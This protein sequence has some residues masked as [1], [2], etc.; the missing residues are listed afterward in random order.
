MQ[1]QARRDVQVLKADVDMLGDATFRDRH[2]QRLTDEL[3]CERNRVKALEMEM[4]DLRV[5]QADLAK[6]VLQK[7]SLVH[8]FRSTV[9]K[10][11]AEAHASAALSTDSSADEAPL[12]PSADDKVATPHSSLLPAVQSARH[13][14]KVMVNLDIKLSDMLSPPKKRSLSATARVTQAVVKLKAKLQHKTLV[15]TRPFPWSWWSY[16]V[17]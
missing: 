3:A 8:R 14:F 5:K 2:V 10:P 16:A 9:Q 15:D 17:A 13:T 1:I 7:H 6:G 4:L 11:T 12:L